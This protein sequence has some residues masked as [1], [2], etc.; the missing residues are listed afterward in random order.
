[1]FRQSVILLRFTLVTACFGRQYWHL[2]VLHI[3]NYLFWQSVLTSLCAS[4]LQLHV[5]AVSADI[6]MCFTFAT[7]CFGSQCW[8]L[9]V[10]HICNY[11]FWQAVILLWFTLVT[12]CFGRQY[13]HLYVL[14]ICNY[15]FWQS[16]LTSLCASHL[17][18][19]VSAVSADIL[20]CFTFATTCFGRQC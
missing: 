3:C 8:H 18:L 2:Y 1:M 20:M 11:L 9:Y 16:V 12:T 19:H 6:F 7:T 5:S 13:W 10:L 4:H 15:M 17:Q 14:H